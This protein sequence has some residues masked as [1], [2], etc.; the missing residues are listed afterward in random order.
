MGH[1]EANFFCS[2]WALW[3]SYCFFLLYFSMFWGCQVLHHLNL[4]YVRTDL[5]DIQV[6]PATLLP[7]SEYCVHRPTHHLWKTYVHL[8]YSLYNVQAFHLPG[9]RNKV[10]LPIPSKR[11]LVFK[12]LCLILTS[13]PLPFLSSLTIKINH[14]PKERF[15]LKIWM[16]VQ[17]LILMPLHFSPSF[18]FYGTGDKLLMNAL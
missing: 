14:L 15:S 5:P 1:Y 17:W 3:N 9:M 2:I 16:P 8:T 13:K 10:K 4:E 11:P 6:C 18:L 12:L 7:S